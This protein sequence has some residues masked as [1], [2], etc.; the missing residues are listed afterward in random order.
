MYALVI[1]LLFYSPMYIHFITSSIL[2]YVIW[3]LGPVV[4]VQW[5]AMEFW[6]C[7]WP[8]NWADKEWDISDWISTKNDRVRENLE[9]YE[10]SRLVSK[11]YENDRLSKGWTP[12]NISE[13][14]FVRRGEKI[15]FE[16]PRLQPLVSTWGAWCLEWASLCRTSGK[17]IPEAATATEKTI[18]TQ[19]KSTEVFFIEYRDLSLWK[20][21]LQIFLFSL[22]EYWHSKPL[23]EDPRYSIST[24]V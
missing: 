19:I 11:S 13:T 24:A 18:D 2:K 7:L 17:T 6:W 8:W 16:V 15:S 10:N 21:E 4:S 12:L 1:S 5:W 3:M 23:G 22:R 20:C 9:E 14:K